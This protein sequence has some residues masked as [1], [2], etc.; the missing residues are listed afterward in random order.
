MVS[1]WRGVRSLAHALSL[2]P[3]AFTAVLS[4]DHVFWLCLPCEWPGL[5]GGGGQGQIPTSPVPLKSPV[6][7]S[8]RALSG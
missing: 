4:G 5:A 6:C 7:L 3:I 8:T 2:F 1:V